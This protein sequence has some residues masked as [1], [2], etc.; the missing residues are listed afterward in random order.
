MS[1]TL[2]ALEGCPYCEAVMDALESNDVAYDVHWVD[3]RFSERDAVK[4]VSGQRSVPV[5][6]HEE[7]GAVLSTAES[8]H[9]YI[10]RALA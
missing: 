7:G 9:D 6:T 10:E 1:V 5:L 4:R 8:I 3:A 2:Y